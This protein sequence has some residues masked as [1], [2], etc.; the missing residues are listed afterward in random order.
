MTGHFGGYLVKRQKIGA[1]ELKKSSAA[2]APLKKK[3]QSRELKSASAQLA[4]VVNRM[5]PALEGKTYSPRLKG[6][7]YVGFA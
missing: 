7:V 3:L 2:L 6:R 5:F 1:F 4:R